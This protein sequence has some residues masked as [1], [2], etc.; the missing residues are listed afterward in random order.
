M[1]SFLNNSDPTLNLSYVENP[2]KAKRRC[3]EDGL[4]SSSFA[5]NNGVNGVSLSSDSKEDYEKLNSIWSK[6]MLAPGSFSLCSDLKV[7]NISLGRMTHSARYPCPWCHWIKTSRD[8]GR[9][10][11]LRTFEGIKHWYEQWAGETNCD[12]KRCKEY[13]NCQQSPMPMFPISGVV[14]DFVPLPELH[15]LLRIVNKLTAELQGKN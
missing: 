7:T 8:I 3:Y 4:K 11:E 6:I 15:L 5:N 9:D 14:L 13:F 1:V 2:P 12:S 10:W